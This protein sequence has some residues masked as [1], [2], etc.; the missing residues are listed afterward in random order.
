MDNI[1]GSGI[2]K[3]SSNSRLV[4]NVHLCTNSLRKG[5]NQSILFHLTPSYGLNSW[6]VLDSNQSKRKTLNS[7]LFTVLLFLFGVKFSL[8][9][10]YLI[11]FFSHVII[12]NC[13]L[14]IVFLIETV[15]FFSYWY[16]YLLL[17]QISK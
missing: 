2:C 15:M 12:S 10:L 9:I 8:D 1:A 17:Y 6:V 4:S 13:F 14:F 5:M 3:L 7:K 16:R 11:Q